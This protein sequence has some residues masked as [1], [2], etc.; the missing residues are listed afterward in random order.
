VES[1]DDV[2]VVLDLEVGD[3]KR[4]RS[5]TE[6]DADAAGVDRRRPEEAALFDAWIEVVHLGPRASLPLSG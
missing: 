4:R 1:V 5:V 6:V 2:A 3:V